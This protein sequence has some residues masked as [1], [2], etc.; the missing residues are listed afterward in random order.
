M[1]RYGKEIKRV[2]T[3]MD[4][5]LKTTGQEYIVGKKFTYADLA[6]IPWNWLIPFLMGPDFEK[7]VEKDLPAY[8]AWWQRV[9]SRP[10]TKKVKKDRE[11]AMAKAH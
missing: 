9:S 4:T 6:F 1:D 7:E 10:A 2:M 11:D 5:H 8:W 3:V